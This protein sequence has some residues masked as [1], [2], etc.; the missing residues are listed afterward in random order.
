[1][2]LVL[3]C[4]F[5]YFHFYTIHNAVPNKVNGFSLD[6]SLSTTISMLWNG[7]NA[8]VDYYMV[9]AYIYM[10]VR[11]FYTAYQLEATFTV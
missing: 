5:L 11:I 7:S 10:H 8:T 9:K 6:S 4:T 3:L 2:K 1:M